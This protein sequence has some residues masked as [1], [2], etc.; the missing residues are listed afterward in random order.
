MKKLVF[1]STVL[2]FASLSYAQNSGQISGN[3][4]TDFQY[5]QP[6][7]LIGAEAPKAKTALMSYANIIYSL[8]D[9]KAGFRYEAYMNAPL[10]YDRRYDGL[11]IPYYFASYTTKDLSLTAGSFYEN[12]GSG[13][14]LRTYED[15]ALGIDN[16]IN[17]IRITAHPYKG[18]YLKALAGK[19]RFFW[20]KGPGIVRGTDGEININELRDSWGNK[21]WGIIIG[22]SF[23]SKFQEDKDPIYK[24]PEN[25]G[26]SAGRI[27]L[28]YGKF[29]LK[30]EYAYKINDPSADNKFIYQDGEALNIEGGYTTKGFGILLAT[31]SLYNMSFRSDRAA[32]LNNLSIGYLPAISRNH[33]FA[34]TAMYPYASQPQGENGFRGDIMYKIP[35]KTKLGGRYGMTIL[36]NGSRVQAVKCNPIND[37]IPI[38]QS[39]TLGYKTQL[40][41]ID[42]EEYF[43]DI[44]LE[45]Q[46]KFSRKLKTIFIYQN[47]FYNFNVMRGKTD[48]EN[49]KAHVGVADITYRFTTKQALEIQAQALF[50]EQDMGNWA[51]LMLEYTV[52]PHWF[53]AVIDQYNYGN[54]EKEKQIH[55]YNTS[56]GYNTGGSRIQIGYGKQRSGIFCVGGV[57]REVPAMYGLTVSISSTF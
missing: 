14:I 33:S 8:K 24:L 18:V 30:S 45:I 28:R 34:F 39:G 36:L 37:S 10:G 23:V 13:L 17:G 9:F 12:F 49:V 1:F 56:F 38:G 5:Y 41:N 44:N 7:S 4:Q 20:D 16:A 48:H 54:S 50:T 3:F 57:C 26:A 43:Q 21:K 31:K 52:A 40:F 46:K 11:G 32:N 42:D 35:K 53:F 2:F 55:Y 6:D 25:V 29:S 27:N 51:M 47:L 15:K 19:Q 22:G